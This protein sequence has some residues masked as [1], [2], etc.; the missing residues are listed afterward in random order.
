MNVVVAYDIGDD[1]RRARVAARLSRFG[2]RI[3][4]SVFD[5]VV[6]EDG[7]AAITSLGEHGIDLDKDVLHVLPQCTT[8]R[9]R[10][11]AFGQVDDVLG[12][13]YWVV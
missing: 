6:D 5:C 13:L 7:L 9:D 12:V 1:D 11:A 8:C 2:V 3:Q 4:R 10:R